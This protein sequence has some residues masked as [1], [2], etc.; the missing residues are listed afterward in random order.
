MQFSRHTVAVWIGNAGRFVQDDRGQDVIEY[1]LLLGLV[2]LTLLGSGIHIPLFHA[3]SRD[4][5]RFSA[6]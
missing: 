6:S 2:G 4:T 1:A 5:A 3:A